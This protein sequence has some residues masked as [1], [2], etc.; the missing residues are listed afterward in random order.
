MPGFS[1]QFQLFIINTVFKHVVALMTQ[2]FQHCFLPV[3]NMEGATNLLVTDTKQQSS[4]I[5]A[6]HK[7]LAGLL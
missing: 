6:C 4:K 5:R 2:N 1:K 3:V 7:L